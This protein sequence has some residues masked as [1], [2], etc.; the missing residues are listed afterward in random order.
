[1]LPPGF[2]LGARPSRVATDRTDGL[3]GPQSLQDITCRWIHTVGLD[4]PGFGAE[5]GGETSRPTDLPRWTDDAPSSRDGPIPA[6]SARAPFGIGRHRTTCD[7]S[8][9]ERAAFPRENALHGRGIKG[10]ARLLRK[11]PISP[12]SSSLHVSQA[13]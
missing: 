4:S 7:G 1:M 6:R 5:S 9:L 11:Y 3:A 13:T 8:H 2:E 12:G 10:T